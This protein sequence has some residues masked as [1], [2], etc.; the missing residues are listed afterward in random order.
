MLNMTTDHLEG[1]LEEREVPLNPVL[2][3]VVGRDGTD[4]SPPRGLF[5]L[6][7]I[8]AILQKLADICEKEC[9]LMAQQFTSNVFPGLILVKEEV[10]FSLQQAN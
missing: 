4:H 3:K 7:Q 10:G 8:N 2:V 1:L 6:D 5:P 9:F